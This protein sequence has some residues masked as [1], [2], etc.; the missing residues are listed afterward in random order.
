MTRTILLLGGSAQ[1][2]V[3]INTAKKLGYTTVLC[4]YL[5]DNPGRQFADVFYLISTTDKEAVLE[6]AKKEK[7]NGVVAYASDPAAPTAA[8]VSE[9]LGLPGIPYGIAK[10]FC[11]KNLF[12]EFLKE[13]GFHAPKSVVTRVG[14]Q[15]QPEFIEGFRF[16]I[17]VKPSD[18]SGSKGVTVV[19][20]LSDIDAALKEASKYSRNG[21]LV[22]EEFIQ[23]DHKHVIE[24]EL[25]IQNG[26]VVVWGLINSIRDK[27]TN[28]LVPAAYSF[29]LAVSQERIVLVKQ[30]IS[31]LI[32]A[33]KIKNGAM[34][35][36]LIIDDRN[37]LYFLDVGPRN[38]GNMLPDFISKI[39]DID[40]VEAT[41]RVAMNDI[42]CIESGSMSDL[43]LGYWGLGVLH[44][45]RSGAFK[46]IKY[47][48]EALEALLVDYVQTD[49]GEP[50]NTFTKCTDLVGLAFFKFNNEALMDDVM[51]NFAKHAYVELD[52]E[53]HE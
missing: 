6:V 35:I 26:E 32:H 12:R 7:I 30:E 51:E 20:N 11:E 25:F 15:F 47:S 49:P 13:N 8:Y 28:P 29:P 27:K 52:G 37:N 43:S 10:A 46:A 48:R 14:E 33:A 21:N 16:P 42:C 17:I 41:L 24:A 45:E 36:E 53:I 40:I 50:V 23:R 34:N 19:D 38:G 31:Q 9:E 22:I 2:V 44:S 4:D 1:Q 5:P 18:A 3:A 39:F